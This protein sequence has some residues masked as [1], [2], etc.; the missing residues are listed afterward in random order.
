MTLCSALNPLT[1]EQEGLNS[2][3]YLIFC[4]FTISHVIKKQ[5]IGFAL[6]LGSLQRQLPLNHTESAFTLL[7]ASLPTS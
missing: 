4:D 2:I 1:T 6:I 5:L 7:T 3:S